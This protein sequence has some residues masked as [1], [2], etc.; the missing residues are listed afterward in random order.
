MEEPISEAVVDSCMTGTLVNGGG[1]GIIH[2]R[3]AG[4]GA[5]LSKYVRGDEDFFLAGRALNRWV[6][7][8][9]VMA[10]NVA[11]IFLVGPAGGAYKG[12]VPILL[13]A[14]SGNMI[15]AVGALFF[16]P[17]FRRLRITTVSEFL[18]E[19]Y[20][21]WLRLLPSILWIVYYTCFAGAAMYTLSVVYPRCSN[22]PNPRSSSSWRDAWCLL[23][24]FRLLAVVYSDVIQAFLIIV[25]GLICCRLP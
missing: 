17:R 14:W 23:L 22:G 1:G 12:G 4:L 11:A 13:I 8:G 9:T 24:R 7:A 19:R 16:V 2:A 15:A 18:E 5:Y 10:T 20:S 6:I 25:G 21:L 3:N